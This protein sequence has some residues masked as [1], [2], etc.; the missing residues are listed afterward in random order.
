MTKKATKLAKL[1]ASI[2]PIIFNICWVDGMMGWSS[3]RPSV[4]CSKYYFFSNVLKNSLQKSFQFFFSF[5]YNF[6]K[7]KSLECPKSKP[8]SHFTMRTNLLNWC[9]LVSISKNVVFYAFLVVRI[10]LI[11]WTFTKYL[12]NL[13]TFTQCLVKFT[14]CQLVSYF[15]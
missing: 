11:L 7:I 12:V 1:L 4:W 3:H 14:K 13:R 6:T 10:L 15:W 8:A 2:N 9:N 5:F